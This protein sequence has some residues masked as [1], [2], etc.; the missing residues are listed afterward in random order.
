MREGV[1]YGCND[2]KNTTVDS[3]HE[4]EI[5]EVG[6]KE[7]KKTSQIKSPVYER[8]EKLGK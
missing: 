4:R 1:G 8:N 2:I 6:V 7:K 3:P 5:R